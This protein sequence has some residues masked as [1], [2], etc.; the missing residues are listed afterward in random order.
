M[1]KMLHITHIL[2]CAMNINEEN[3]T[4]VVAVLIN[5]E[6]EFFGANMTQ[7]CA[8][9]VKWYNFCHL[10]SWAVINGVSASHQDILITLA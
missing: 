1:I 2:N 9:R 10:C 6:T 4:L 3:N 8:P 5:E 7:G